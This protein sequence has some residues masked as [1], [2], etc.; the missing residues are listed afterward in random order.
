MASGRRIS[1][2]KDDPAGQG[3]GADPVFCILVLT[4][5]AVGL[6]MLYSASSAQSM[7]DTG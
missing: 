5:L 6:V 1:F 7:Y 4:A 2:A 3:R